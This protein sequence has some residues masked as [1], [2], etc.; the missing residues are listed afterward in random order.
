M[1]TDILRR[2]WLD[3]P[4][5]HAN[6]MNFMVHLIFIPV[7][8]AGTVSLCF[9]LYALSLAASLAGLAAMGL[10]MAIQGWGHRQEALPPEPFTSGVNALIRILLEQWLTFPAYVLCLMWKKAGRIIA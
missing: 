1:V 4:K 3:Y 2:Q 5:T 9:G 10:A 7:F 8:M 6:R